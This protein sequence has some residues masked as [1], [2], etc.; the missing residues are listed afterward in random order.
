MWIALFRR[1]ILLCLQGRSDDRGDWSRRREAAPRRD[2]Y[3][4]CEKHLGE[5]VMPSIGDLTAILVA[6]ISHGKDRS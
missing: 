5:H 1:N 3:T 2:T 4:F 6:V